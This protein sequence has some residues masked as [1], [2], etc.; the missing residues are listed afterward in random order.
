MMEQSSA[1]TDAF[2]NSGGENTII[3][4]GKVGHG[5]T[6][7]LNKIC[8]TVYQSEM[9]ARS[10]TRVLQCD[11]TILHGI[12]VI[13][14]PGFYSSEKIKS[15]T[16]NQREAI[17]QNELSGIYVVIK[18]GRSDEMAETLNKIMNFVGDEGIRIIM[19]HVDS[20]DMDGSVQETI[21]RL[22][23]LMYRSRIHCRRR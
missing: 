3:L 11:C 19:T 7:I 12:T 17:E 14:T 13:D 6:F 22:S 8:G 18:F 2:V 20:D 15:H 23:D 21:N 10:C 5:K 1:C 4:V 9:C 16:A